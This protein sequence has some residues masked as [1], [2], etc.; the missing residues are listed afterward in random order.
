M[1]LV[2]AKNSSAL[3]VLFV[4]DRHGTGSYVSAIFFPA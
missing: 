4:G 3:P 2:L 1:P